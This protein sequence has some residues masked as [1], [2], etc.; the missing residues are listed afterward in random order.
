MS[1]YI[2]YCSC[3]KVISQCRCPSPHKTKTTVSNG[4]ASCKAKSEVKDT[5]RISGDELKKRL[6]K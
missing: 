3:G 4:C 1:H 5:T 6:G 2:Q